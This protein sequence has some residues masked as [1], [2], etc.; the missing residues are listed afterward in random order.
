MAATATGPSGAFV[1]GEFHTQGGLFLAARQAVRRGFP[2]ASLGY[3]GDPAEDASG[4]PLGFVLPASYSREFAGA[5]ALVGLLI[6]L[7]T[8]LFLPWISL[9]HSLSRLPGGLAAGLLGGLALGGSLG[10]ALV[11]H[12]LGA[13]LTHARAGAL[14]LRIELPTDLPETE[15][16][17]LAELAELALREAKAESLRHT[18]G[19]TEVNSPQS[20]AYV[21]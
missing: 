17:R 3:V 19:A 12:R 20:P 7:L 10:W 14:R 4:A 11:S 16:D 13:Y 8:A 9:A 1:S 18:D 21:P 6:G 15:R 2:R 5:G